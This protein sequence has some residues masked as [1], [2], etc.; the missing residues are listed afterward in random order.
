MESMKT[1]V[2]P[3]QSYPLGATYDGI[4]TNFT[5]FS[6]VAERVELRT[7]HAPSGDPAGPAGYLRRPGASRRDRAP[8][9]PGRHRGGA[10]LLLFNAHYE[11]VT[12]VL[13]G[14]PWGEQW[15]LDFDTAVVPLPSE[16]QPAGTKVVVAARA[17]QIFRRV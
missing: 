15:L 6:E 11:D 14:R 7:Q 4:G 13:P 3:G 2:W 12:F 10:F 5:L 9:P 1:E 17:V 16:P 8:A